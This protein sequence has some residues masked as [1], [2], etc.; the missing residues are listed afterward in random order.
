M[1][2]PK[3]I[4]TLPLHRHGRLLLTHELQL[5]L[6]KPIVTLECL[7]SLSS[8]RVIR[9]MVLRQDLLTTSIC[10]HVRLLWLWRLFN[11]LSAVS[12]LLNQLDQ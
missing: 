3:I 5:R 7:Q 6:V 9:R 4:P 1:L 2:L 11:L 10:H 12:V 8:H